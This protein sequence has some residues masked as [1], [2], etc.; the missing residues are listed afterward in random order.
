LEGDLKIQ[1]PGL[2]AM[3]VEIEA[4]KI[5]DLSIDFVPIPFIEGPST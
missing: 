3:S 2:K 5:A 4:A 1:V